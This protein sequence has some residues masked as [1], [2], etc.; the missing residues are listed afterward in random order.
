MEFGGNMSF[1]EELI[2]V[3]EAVNASIAFKILQEKE[4][5]EKAAFAAKAAA[6]KKAVESAKVVC[7]EVKAE[8]SNEEKILA[9]EE[10]LAS[11]LS[12][13][14]EKRE[15]FSYNNFVN[16]CKRT[17]FLLSVISV[18]EQAELSNNKRLELL[19]GTKK[20]FHREGSC[21]LRNKK[22]REYSLFSKLTSNK[23]VI[24]T[25]LVN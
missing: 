1:F 20:W 19:Y 16:Y 21:F 24:I 18:W 23:E 8:V 3:K 11:E 25:N 15:Y 12:S 17:S 7:S 14:F 4:A 2:D 10:A 6:D 22:T 9:A 5:A 13:F